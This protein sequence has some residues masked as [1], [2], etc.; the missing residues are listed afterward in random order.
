MHHFRALRTRTWFAISLILGFALVTFG[1]ATDELVSGKNR[2]ADA[3]FGLTAQA[4]P[5]GILLTLSN[6]PPDT[7]HLWITV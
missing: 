1:C 6:I 3:D 2:A 4:V 7:N 5:E